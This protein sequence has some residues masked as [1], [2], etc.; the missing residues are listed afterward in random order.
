MSSSGICGKCPEDTVY[1]WLQLASI[2]VSLFVLL[3][4]CLL[5]FIRQTRYA[6]PRCI[7]RAIASSICRLPIRVLTSV[8]A[9]YGL[10]SHI[11]RLERQMNQLLPDKITS[12]PFTYPN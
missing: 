4:L 6:P 10:S 5:F 3:A 8:Q 7:F 9:S 11:N 12:P 1:S 2:I